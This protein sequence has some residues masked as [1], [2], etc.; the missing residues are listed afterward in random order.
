M[1]I[2]RLFGLVN[3][4]TTQSA[5]R[6][7][8]R[9]LRPRKERRDAG[10][11][12]LVDVVGLAAVDA[13]DDDRTLG[14]AIGAAVD[15]ERGWRAAVVHRDLR[16]A[17]TARWRRAAAAARRLALV[18][19]L[20]AGHD[21]VVERPA[22]GGGVARGDLVDDVAVLAR[23]HRQR[24]ALGQRL[25][26]EQVQ[27][28]DQPAVGREQLGVA[29]ERDQPVVEVE[30][31]QPVGVRRRPWPRRGPCARRKRAARACARRVAVCASRRPVHSSS[32]A[33]TS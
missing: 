17:M 5:V 15:G 11:D 28:V 9:S 1:T 12:R 24:A 22:G 3:D 13:D 16:G 30:I 10:F 20:A 23:R 4:G 6:H 19:A 32:A 26:A 31:Q 33:R 7:V 18:H 8:P 25:P 2:D 14:P 29:G 27:F 21:V